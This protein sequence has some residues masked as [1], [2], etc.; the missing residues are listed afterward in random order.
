[1]KLFS[2]FKRER[3]REL[4]PGFPAAVLRS[5]CSFNHSGIHYITDSPVARVVLMQTRNIDL[6]VLCSHCDVRPAFY[7]LARGRIDH[8]YLHG[9]FTARFRICDVN[10]KSYVIECRVFDDRA[11]KLL[12]CERSQAIVVNLKT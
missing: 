10:T 6:F 9:P 7:G 1:M 12:V 4:G 5:R 3:E 2:K 8:D 11:R